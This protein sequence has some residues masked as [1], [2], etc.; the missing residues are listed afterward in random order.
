MEH[1]I[2]TPIQSTRLYEKLS[3]QIK[4]QILNGNLKD[5]DRL[6]NERQLAERFEVS[7]TVVR[8]AIKT[9]VNEG[10]VEVRS[11]R[12]TFVIDDTSGALRHSLDM[13][14]SIGQ[15]GAVA[16]VVEIRGLLEPPIAALAADRA[17]EEDIASMQEAVIAMDASMD[18][19]DA[20]IAADHAFHLALAKGTQNPIIPKLIDSI[21]DLLHEQRKGIFYVEGGPQRG[22]LH[23]KRI[24][25]GVVGH[26][27]E[28][29]REAMQAHLQQV[30]DDN[31]SAIEQE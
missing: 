19:V 21:V 8:E 3:Q 28:A 6:P 5:G 9:L 18:D 13:V 10:L 7:R 11:G 24:L 31:S 12:G 15:A 23:H 4:D 25:A 20:F 29:A 30:S 1:H 16:N 14:M 2:Y 22:Q 27:P 26:D 17:T